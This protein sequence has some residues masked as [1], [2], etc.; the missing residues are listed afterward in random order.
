VVDVDGDG[1]ASAVERAI[2]DADTVDWV[3]LA[4]STT[5][6]SR[7]AWAGSRSTRL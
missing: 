1:I 4:D 2:G 6:R 5:N 3:E 7:S